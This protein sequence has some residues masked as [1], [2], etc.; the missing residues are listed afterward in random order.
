MN[1]DQPTT[2]TQ[3]LLQSLAMLGDCN[4]HLHDL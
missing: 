4:G 1:A 2:F 3:W